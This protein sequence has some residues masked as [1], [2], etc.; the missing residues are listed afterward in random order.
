MKYCIFF[1]LSF[2][3]LTVS[4][5]LNMNL[6]SN[7][8]YQQLHNAELNDVWGYVDETGKE[9]AL[10][11][12][13]KGTS[14]VDI[15][16]PV[17]PVEIFWEPGLESI[18][19]DLK[20]WGDYAYI[21]TEAQNGLLI[22]DL[23]SLPITT[24]ITA[25]YYTGDISE[26]YLL[27]AHN[28]YIDE[29]GR[30]Y[31]FGS[32]LGTGGVQILD[33]ATNPLDPQ[34]IGEFDDW[35]VHDGVVRND[36]LFLAH[37]N[38]GFFSIVDIST[39]ASPVVLGTKTTP[40]IFAHNIWPSDDGQFVFTTDEVSGAFVAAYD[41]SN[42]ANIVEVDR[43]QSSP[44]ANVIPHNT[45]VKGNFLV[46]SYYSD[47]IVVHDATHPNNLIEV[48]N[49]DTYPLQTAGYDGCWGAY[50]YLPSGHV[51]ATDRE[52]GLFVL[53]INYVQAA[54]LEGTVTDDVTSNPIQGVNV[55]IQ[56]VNNLNATNVS[57]DYA[58]G[59]AA[60]GTVQVTYQ[61]VG[62][63]SVVENVTLTNG[64]VT[65][66]DVEL[67]AIPPYTIQVTVLDA[68]TLDP[69]PFAYVR[70]DGEFLT[71]EG[72]TNGLGEEDLTMYYEEIYT[73]TAGIWGHKTKC[74]DQFVDATTGAITIMLDQGYWDDFSFDFG[75]VTAGTAFEG[76]WT[77]AIPFGTQENANPDRDAVFDCGKYA[78]VTGNAPDFNL[79]ADDVENG[80]VKLFSPIMDLTTYTNPHIN[81]ARWFYVRYGPS[82]PDDS[83]KIYLSNGTV[84]VLIDTMGVAEFYDEW[85]YKS[86]RVEDFMPVTST[87]QIRV[88]T[89][90]FDPFWNVV[91]AGFD[92]FF[93]SEYNTMAIEKVVE[94]KPMSLYPNPSY[95]IVTLKN[96]IIG[97]SFSIVALDGKIVLN[98]LI[99]NEEEK[100]DIQGLKSGI[101][102]IKSGNQVLR[103][104][105]N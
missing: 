1:I 18:W 23:T 19:R 66:N 98:G 48:A 72:S 17:N 94:N 86:L 13:T 43:V 91:E 65:I 101:Y 80:D 73:I 8:D 28:L 85:I 9:Y 29:I 30:A 58:T 7:I 33:V 22:L 93:I 37:I 70:F 40:N 47:G 4:G 57:G 38:D 61:K 50:P 75:W 53:G 45:H 10:V 104:M 49:F 52:E 35:Y 100:I 89:S 6:L 54:Y 84:N 60:G 77:R 26:G 62:Y 76:L 82:F 83:L 68:A 56:G 105:K 11:G 55:I 88:E 96:G 39:L 12:T 27:S 36:T 78:Y 99:A 103:L 24:G 74:I 14:V 21:T 90:D 67:T 42:P 16:D 44:G 25:S 92:R 34:R 20:T 63:Y 87:M 5:Q 79:A 46:T 3:T 69:I 2:I 59:S 15:S 102:L 31:I 32:N 41:I 81:Y 95:S 97:E 51:L 64:V 71:H